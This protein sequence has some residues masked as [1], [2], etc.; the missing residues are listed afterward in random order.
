MVHIERWK[1]I[2]I[3]AICLVGLVYAAPHLLSREQA[4]AIP[5]WLP[6]Q[7]VNLGLDLQGGSHLLLEV[8]V[9]AVVR[10]R[11]TNLVDGVRTAMRTQRIAITNLASEGTSVTFRVREAAQADQAL[12]GVR[13]LDRAARAT[14]NP[15][16]SIVLRLDEREL[17]DQRRKAVSQSIEIVRRRIDGLG[18]RDPTIQA[19]G[20][21]RILVQLP[22]VREPERVKALL[23]KTAKLTFH[24][25][26][27]TGEITEA[28]AG[29]M[30]PGSLL[31][32]DDREVEAGGQPRLHLLQRRVSVAGE[33]LTRADPGTNPQTGEWVVNFSF[34]S[35]GARQFADI[36]R[37]N[38][39]R[40]F[41]IVLDGRVISAPVIREPILAGSG[42]ISG[43][44]T[45]A[46]AN[47]L[48]VLL[49]AGAL[50]A[51]LNVIEERTVGPDLGSDSIRAGAIAIVIG[52][53]LIAALMIVGYGLFGVVANI[54]L[55]LNIA[56][57]LA[58]M[59]ALGATLTL[60]GLAG[61]VLGLAMA[62]DAN[63]LIYERMREEMRAGRSAYPA[64]DFAF[65]RAYG[66]ILDSNL[67]TLI[68]A[69]LLYVFGAGPIRGFAVTLSIGIICSMFT[70]VTV[71]R[72]LIVMW[73]DWRRPK[74]LPV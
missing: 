18:T 2:A 54:A 51:P 40:P 14:T 57:T 58:I 34:D 53:V 70:A 33:R 61:M 43:N 12:T 23:G 69:L 37:E 50:P 30:P 28:R 20:Q 13:D 39:G 68:A 3:F 71:T 19:Q 44:F 15:D 36:T 11:L 45:V 5:A 24:L 64:A 26:D 10:E 8:D 52:Y 60:P 67:T 7:Q 21:D 17:I 56:F 29:R 41:A 66:T 16:Q 46:S 62:V 4:E 32:P 72:M 25:F 6:R 49:R 22:G 55:I 65:Q 9:A 42:Q 74:A 47:D 1:I 48:S 27:R 38:V 73:L 59:A 31:V 63:V 35:V